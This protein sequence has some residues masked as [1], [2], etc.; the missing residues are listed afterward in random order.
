MEHQ[1]TQSAKVKRVTLVDIADPEGDDYG[2]GTYIY[3]PDN[4]FV[5][6][7]FDLLRFRMLE[8]SD[9]Y[10]MEFHFKD[11]GGNPWNGPNGFSL[12]IIEVYFYFTDGGNTSAIKMFPNDPGSNVQLDPRH[13]W[14]LALRIAGWDYRNRIVLPDGTVYQGEM[15][16]SADPVKNAIIVK[17][18]KKYLSITDY[19]LYTAV[20]V[21][22]Q[23]GYGPDKWRPVAVEAEQWKLGGADPQAVI[24]NLAPRV[25]D[26]LVP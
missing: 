23:D 8:Q 19:G 4:V 14:D 11:L 18:P 17:A 15:Q 21:G 12:Q 16:I 3:P 2:P 26:M 13:P 1:D 20:L 10:V 24:D 5:P 9:A 25:V 22:S 6:G 7:A